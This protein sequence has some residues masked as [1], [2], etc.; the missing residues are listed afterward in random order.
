MLNW[1]LRKRH[2]RSA[3]PAET[4]ADAAPAPAAAAAPSR[5]PWEGRLAAA[6]GD[7]S[8]LLELA[9]AA[10]LLDLKLAAVEAL[11]GEA[12]LKEAE[13]EFRR[14]DRKVHQRARQRLAA[15][16]ARRE[17]RARAEALIA[18]ASEL[19]LASPLAANRLAALDRDWRALDAALLEPG[20]RDTFAA[21]RDRLDDVLRQQ[22]EALRAERWSAGAASALV[23]L[24]RAVGD[25][26]GS[27]AIERCAKAVR[28]RLGER[29]ALE[30]TRALG[31]ALEAELQA[32]L[33][34]V[35]VSGP[36]AAPEPPPAPPIE[37]A[38]E[39]D[40]DAGWHEF[41]RHLARAE[42]A[43]AEGRTAQLQQQLQAAEAALA[44]RPR[45]AADLA[46]GLRARL[47]ALHAERSRLKGWQQWG[48]AIARDALVDEAEALA[49]LTQA[50]QAEPPAA[51]LNLKAHGEAIRRL[52]A[53]WKELDRSGAAASQALWQ[54]FDAALTSAHAPVAAQQAALKAARDDNL[55]AREA[56]LAGL[57]DAAQRVATPR[58]TLQ[59]L[60]EFQ[61][62]WRQLG[63]IQH[64]VPAAAAAPLQQRQTELVV[65]IEAPL[66]DARATAQREREALVARAEALAAAEDRD[67]LAQLRALQAEWQQHARALPLARAAEAALWSRFRQATDAVF[68]RRE[69]EAQ[70]RDAEAAAGL[71][72]R[73]ALLE[74]VQAI[75]DDESAAP[76]DSARLL[77]QLEREWQQLF[78]PLPRAVA[79]DLEA[80]WRAARGAA[81]LAT[82]AR[83]RARW[84]RQCDALAERLSL[85]EAREAGAADAEDLRRR[86]EAAGPAPAPWQRVLEQRWAGG[87]GGGPSAPAALDALLLRLEDALGVEPAPAQAQ[88]RRDLRLLAL[89][90][91]LEGRAAA[92]AAADGAG[93]AA[94]LGEL[95][96]QPRLEPSEAARLRALLGAVRTSPQR[97]GASSA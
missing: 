29:P 9:R 30:E 12:A 60:D 74:R 86:W 49:R 7:D 92:A 79:D 81:A 28:A 5:A 40:P 90:D 36:A 10:P 66:A 26:A 45:G 34:R 68:A 47:Q 37:R 63:P 94:W 54:R 95:L 14:H 27:A 96:R 42:A 87:D 71:A 41:E 39:P 3:V 70:A 55:A 56:L 73:E 22:D 21:L 62:A 57:E 67:A 93:A 1:L 82:E 59:A 23:E 51:R 85:C 38:K 13:R 91:A 16:V 48:G 17:A 52:R 32:A 69:A 19:A 8:A 46:P 31:Q 15:A 11:T 58:D 33:A 50:A 24:Q 97:F 80:R 78:T 89:K 65:R 75:A 72:A 76:D 25:G 18:V 6:R 64:T 43:L 84:E 2:H 61:R 35:A 83:R 77:G 4:T 88:A 53:R 44:E 20:Q